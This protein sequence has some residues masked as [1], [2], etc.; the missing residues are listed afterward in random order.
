[1][2][3]VEDQIADTVFIQVG[4]EIPMI[5][6]DLSFIT[7]GLKKIYICLQSY[8]PKTLD[9][10]KNA[11]ED[12]MRIT[13]GKDT[14]DM[15]YQTITGLKHALEDNNARSAREEALSADNV[16]EEEEEDSDC[17]GEASSSEDETPVDKK[18][19]RKENKKKVKEENRER[20]KKKVP[21]AIK[22]KREKLAKAR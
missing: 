12:V 5:R 6:S 10:V 19:A 20:R 3:S 1:M 21:K 13:S 11:E 16:V 22:K 2:I 8:I 14:G 18:A 9:D 17:V 7:Y 15:L 4:S